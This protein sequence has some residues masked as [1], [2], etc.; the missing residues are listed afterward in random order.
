MSKVHELVCET[1]KELGRLTV[2][3]LQEVRA[4]WLAELEAASALEWIKTYCSEMCRLVIEKK[5]TV[6]EG[7]VIM[8]AIQIQ[9]DYWMNHHVDTPQ[10]AQAWRLFESRVDGIVP[11]RIREAL[12]S[13]FRQYIGELELQAFRGGF[14]AAAALATECMVEQAGAT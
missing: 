10:V 8:D 3:E 11:P 9:H 12:E 5:R 14:A 2:S 6:C 7:G 1:I 13:E 4:E